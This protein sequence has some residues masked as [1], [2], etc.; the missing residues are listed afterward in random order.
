MDITEALVLTGR[1]RIR[2]ILMTALTTI[3]ALTTMVFDTSS[4]AELM[5]PMAVAT[6]GGL[7]Y[8]TLLTLFLVP[9]LYKLFHRKNKIK[10]EAEEQ[11]APV[12]G[13]TDGSN[14]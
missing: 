7:A 14:G 10:N 1:H 2:P 3:I 5:R 11:S 13:I 12:P 8:S 6:I 9:S 4:G